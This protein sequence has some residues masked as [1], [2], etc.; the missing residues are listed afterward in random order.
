[1]HRRSASLLGLVAMMS[2]LTL[3]LVVPAAS[4]GDPC[5]HG[6]AMPPAS[7]GSATEI[8]LEPC[9]FAPTVTSVAVGSTVTFRNG[10]NFTHLI[11][12][13]NQAWGSRDVEVQP[14]QVVAYDFDAAGTYPYACAL[15]SGMSG[16]IVVGDVASSGGGAAGAGAATTGAVT[17]PEASD[18]ASGPTSDP[19]A[20]GASAAIGMLLGA[21]V[22]WVALRRRTD[23]PEEP[24]AGIA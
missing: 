20:I 15:H 22:V 23:T 17:T 21:L 19:L 24:V 4:A 7:S 10:P 14:N 11:T 9:A 12:G 3:W 16:V 6:F 13:A 8:K 2:A 5:F 1:M 18:G